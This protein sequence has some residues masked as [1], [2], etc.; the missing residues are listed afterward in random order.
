[1]LPTALVLS[2]VGLLLAFTSLMTGNV[3]LAGGAGLLIVTS[4]AL[5][6]VVGRRRPSRHVTR[7]LS[8][9]ELE[10]R[11]AELEELT[12]PSSFRRTDSS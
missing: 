11:L 8:D 3:P 5:L 1:M 7:Q 6:A 9:E 4:L 2:V 10:Q 12:R